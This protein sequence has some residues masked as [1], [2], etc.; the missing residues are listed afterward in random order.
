MVLFIFCLGL[1]L[2]SSSLAGE[3]D[4]SALAKVPIQDGGRVKPLDTFARESVRMVTGREQFEGL[5]SLDTLMQWISNP[6]PWDTKECILVE[7]LG[8]KDMLGIPKDQ[9]R[10]MP[11]SLVHNEGFITYATS[12]YEKQQKKMPLNAVDKEAIEVFGRLQRLEDIESGVALTLIPLPDPT[13]QQWAS[14]DDFRQAYQ[15]D[16]AKMPEAAKEI[17]SSSPNS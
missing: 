12:C 13:T 10:A 3:M 8:L 16:G 6:A 4:Y 5:D 14:L 15:R 7:N 1:G 11:V 2:G 17:L 9:K